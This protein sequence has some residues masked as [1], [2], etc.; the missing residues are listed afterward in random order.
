M[1]IASCEY[2]FLQPSEYGRSVRI[3]IQDYTGMMCEEAAEE[4]F[5]CRGRDLKSLKY[6][7]QGFAQLHDILLGAVCKQYV[8]QLK[9]EGRS[10]QPAFSKVG[11]SGVHCSQGREGESIS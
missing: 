5:G 7:E 1:R 6:N 8:F 4:I 3:Q 10:P 2:S 9:V 11:I